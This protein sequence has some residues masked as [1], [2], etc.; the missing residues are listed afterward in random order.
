MAASR[1]ETIERGIPMTITVNGQTIETFSGESIASA[2]MASGK[3]IFRHTSKSSQPRGFFCGMGMCFDCEAT[4]DG[5]PHVRT[6]MKEVHP[7]C[8]VELD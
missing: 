1:C 3:R 6:C 8:V 5:V 7:D 4:V 2:I